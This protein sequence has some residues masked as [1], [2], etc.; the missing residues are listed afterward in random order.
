MKAS[1]LLISSPLVDEIQVFPAQ[2][3]KLLLPA[4][5]RLR[6]QLPAPQLG[7]VRAGVD[8]CRIVTLGH[9]GCKE[10][11]P[12]SDSSTSPAVLTGLFWSHSWPS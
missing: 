6:P 9:S 3:E 2:V 10:T 5:D 4:A 11:P 8:L 7:R 1:E 12:S